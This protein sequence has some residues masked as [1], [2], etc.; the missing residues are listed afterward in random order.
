DIDVVGRTGLD[1]IHDAEIPCVINAT[2]EALRLP[3]FQVQI[4]NRKILGDLLRVAR[5]DPEHLTRVLRV[6]DKTHR[7]EVEKPREGVATE[8]V[9]ARVIPAVLDLIRCDSIAEAR[10]ILQT[11]EAGTG[12]LDELQAV[13]ESA[14]ALGMPEARLRPNFAIARG[15]DYYTG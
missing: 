6:I 3:D 15:L 7:E 10:K 14:I 8:G 4:S 2:F 12:G 5:P 9:D 1:P 11:A 13:M